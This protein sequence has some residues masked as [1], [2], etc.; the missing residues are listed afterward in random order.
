MSALVGGCQCGQVRYESNAQPL[1]S[2]NCHCRECQSDR[3]GLRA[4]ISRT[5]ELIES[6]WRS[7]ILREPRR[8]RQHI[9]PRICPDC[10]SRIFGKTSGFPQFVL[11]TAGSLNDPSC[12]NRPWIFSLRACNPGIT[13]IPSCRSS[14]SSRKS[15][16]NT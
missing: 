5:G 1:F 11:I 9:Q 4:R 14:R 8:Q 3:R 10:G 13:W 15:E 12:L 6:N 16:P 7:E 2:G